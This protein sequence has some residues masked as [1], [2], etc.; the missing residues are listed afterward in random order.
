MLRFFNTLSRKVEEILSF[1]AAKVR[2]YVCGLSFLNFSYIENF[3][4]FIFA[5]VLR[6][7]L[8]FKCYDVLHVFNLTDVDD[9]IIIEPANRHITIDEF[10]APYIQYFWE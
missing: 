3:H 5:N 8:K 2:I 4:T 9:H 7:Y 6:R 1:E 10:T